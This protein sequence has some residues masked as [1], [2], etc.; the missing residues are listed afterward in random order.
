MQKL[1]G[2][3]VSALLFIVCFNVFVYERVCVTKLQRNPIK[4]LV[5]SQK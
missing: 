2:H 4:N 1:R 3:Y 5:Q